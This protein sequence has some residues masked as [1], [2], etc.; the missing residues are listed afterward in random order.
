MSIKQISPPILEKG[1]TVAII[2]PSG[3]VS[4][5]NIARSVST[6]K[7]WGLN[8]I[9]GKSAFKKQG[10][11]AGKDAERLADLQWAIE[12]DEIDVILC[13]RGG[14]GATRILDQID[15][16][17]LKTKPKWLVG[18]SDI[19][20]LHLGL[21]RFGVKS[22]HGPMATSFQRDGAEDSTAALQ[23]LLFDG[24]S[25]S[26]DSVAS[27]Y[28]IS[29]KGHGQLTGGNLA[30][31][32]DSL[33]TSSEVD[34]DGKLLFLE[35]IGEAVYKIDRMITQLKRAGKFEHLEGLILGD[36]SEV[37]DDKPGPKWQEMICECLTEYKFPIGFGFPIGHEPDNRP[38]IMGGIY[39]F[40]IKGE[41]GH[42]ALIS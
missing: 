40:E 5:Q 19:T 28:N 16:S 14:Y 37:G 9:I 24:K 25:T 10:Y 22:I 42:L 6:L 29:G 23:S 27:P 3:P 17:K 38:I 11:L 36:F 26:I 33:G 18:Y 34:T 32:V 7:N 39:D 35:D 31:V 41:K 13:A 30:L 20:A 8:V 12:T 2:A 21:Q 15:L 1:Q 4:S